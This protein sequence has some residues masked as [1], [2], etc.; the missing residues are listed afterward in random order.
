[1]DNQTTKTTLVS[2]KLQ[3][4]AKKCMQEAVTEAISNKLQHGTSTHCSM[5]G[6]FNA[7]GF[8]SNLWQI[9][10]N[11]KTVREDPRTGREARVVCNY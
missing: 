8:K 6:S 7:Q 3:V 5:D 2:M 4:F 11:Y 1:M 9:S 10:A